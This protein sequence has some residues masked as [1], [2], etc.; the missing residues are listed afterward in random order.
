MDTKRKTFT[1]A[2]GRTL[3][4]RFGSAWRLGRL[5]GL[6]DLDMVK[7]GITDENLHLSGVIEDEGKLRLMVETMIE[8]EP[9]DEILDSFTLADL[10]NLIVTFF[11]STT[12]ATLVFKNG[13]N[14]SV[15]TTRADHLQPEPRK[16]SHLTSP[17]ITPA[18]EELRK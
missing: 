9:T 11:L 7:E 10:I 14:G 13:L 12:K 3:T 8:E 6:I 4:L 17:S 2:S 15:S 1:T 5:Q 18:E 16:D